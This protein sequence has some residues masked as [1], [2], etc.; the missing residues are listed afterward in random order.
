MTAGWFRPVIFLSATFLFTASIFASE[1]ESTS[2]PSLTLD[3]ADGLYAR[4]MYEPAAAE[5]QKFIRQNPVSPE[6]ASARFRLAD[7]YYFLKDYSTAVLHFEI[8]SRDFPLDARVPMARYRSGSARYYLGDYGGAVRSLSRINNLTEDPLVRSGALFYLGKAVGARKKPVQGI[9]FFEA[10]LV[11]FPSSE[12]AP[13]AGLA[14]GDFYAAEGNYQGAIEAFQKAAS[15]GAPTDLADEARFKIGEIYFLRRDYASARA[16]YERLFGDKDNVSSASLKS[17]ALLGLFYCD[18]YEKNRAA[19]EERLAGYRALAEADAHWPDICYLLADL[20]QEDGDTLTGLRYLDTL[21][22]DQR[23]PAELREKALLKKALFLE[24][25]GRGEEGLSAIEQVLAMSSADYARALFQKARSLSILG[26][27]EEAL[28]I[29]KK[30]LS[31]F[32]RTDFAKQAFFESGRLYLKVG[33]VRAARDTFAR[34]VEKH[35]SGEMT[36]RCWLETI[37]IDLNAGDFMA[38]SQGVL[39]FMKNFP[40]SPFLDIA[41][42]KRGI[43]MTGLRKFK[44]AELVF[45]KITDDFPSSKLYPEALYGLAASRES[46]GDLAAAISTYEKLAMDYPDYS[47]TKEML[48][49]LAQIYLRASTP[50]KA[51]VVYLDILENKPDITISKKEA[52]WLIQTFL[53]EGRFEPM[54]KALAR[55]EE[56]FPDED[57]NHEIQ[58]FLGEAAMGKQEFSQA[59]EHYSRSVDSKPEGIFAAYAFLGAGI[60]HAA[61]GNSAEA[62]KNFSEVLKYDSE[63]RAVMR[64]RFELA[65]L[66]LKARDLAAAANGFMLVAI[67]YDDSKYVPLSLYKAGECFTGIGRFDDARKA[68]DELKSRYPESEWTRKIPVLAEEVR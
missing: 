64:A 40:Q 68:F 50:D 29:Y 28:G 66:R 8:F 25:M 24:N 56:R 16:Y 63:T 6:L 58:F 33:N 57:L 11:R 60:A 14:I 5:Y 51:A 59:V 9:R 20:S 52:F 65:G 44:E 55:L 47:L 26:R 15:A 2:N 4:R 53:D 35:P 61:L 54:R 41:L 36:E 27:N 10:L 37:Q 13:Y 19:A 39:R 34:F 32:S 31:E 1:A 23:S 3:F 62:E 43:A 45:S 18:F 38:A 46:Q 22:N 30:I 48:P 21:L 7:S 12:Y 42:Y 67:L 49:H 17:K